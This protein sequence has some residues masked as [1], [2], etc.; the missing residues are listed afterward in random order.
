MTVRDAPVDVV[1]RGVIAR[2]VIDVVML[3][4]RVRRVVL[5]ESLRLL[6]VVDLVGVV[7]LLPLRR[8]E[9]QISQLLLRA[10]DSWLRQASLAAL[11]NLLQ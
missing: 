9:D 5:R 1:D 3:V 10:M 2:A 8:V 6:S 4:V 7:V 11:K